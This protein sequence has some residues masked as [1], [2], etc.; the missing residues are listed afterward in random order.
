MCHDNYPVVCVC[1][2]VGALFSRRESNKRTKGLRLPNTKPNTTHYTPHTSNHTRHHTPQTTHTHTGPFGVDVRCC[3]NPGNAGAQ[4]SLVFVVCV[5]A[6]AI[7]IVVLFCCCVCLGNAAV[8]MCW[9]LVHAQ[10]NLLHLNLIYVAALCLGILCPIVDSCQVFLSLSLSLSLFLLFS[11]TCKHTMSRPN[12]L[13]CIATLSWQCFC[14]YA[15]HVLHICELFPFIVFALPLCCCP[16][17]CGNSLSVRW[18]VPS[19][20]GVPMSVFCLCRPLDY[21]V[22]LG[23]MCSVSGLSCGPC[24]VDLGHVWVMVLSTYVCTCLSVCA[25]LWPIGITT[26]NRHFETD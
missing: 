13:I 21:V 15:F 7:T 1:E 17:E 3:F 18:C 2:H 5:C 16:F 4:H 26:H 8:E 14:A 6:R 24:L 9:C 25:L 19:L 23:L 12:C 11:H 10:R 20:D 22:N